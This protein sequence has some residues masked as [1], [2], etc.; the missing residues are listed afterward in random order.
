[1]SGENGF[2]WLPDVSASGILSWSKSPSQTVP[3]S[4]NVKGQKGDM[5]S[6][7]ATGA[8][9]DP[10][11]M[12]GVNL[13]INSCFRSAERWAFSPYGPSGSFSVLDNVA[14]VNLP[15]NS[16]FGFVGI[17]FDMPGDYTYSFDVRTDNGYQLNN[18]HFVGQTAKLLPNIERIYSYWRR[19][20]I[21]FTIET[22]G[23]YYVTVGQ[24]DGLTISAQF[25]KMKLER[26]TKQTP[27]WTPSVMEMAGGTGGFDIL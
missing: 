6:A 5:G 9:G 26:G 20:V 4:V 27:E 14:T 24:I 19:I 2:T 10:G 15:N 21:H 11:E 13:F 3:S 1:S 25:R 12:V 16:R 17:Q 22:V 7:G 23:T 18:I 8:K